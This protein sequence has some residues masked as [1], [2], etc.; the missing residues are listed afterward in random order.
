MEHVDADLVGATGVE[1]TE[2]E[3]GVVFGKGS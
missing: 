1:V 3:A 2:D